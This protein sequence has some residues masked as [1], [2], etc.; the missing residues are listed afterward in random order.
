MREVSGDA[1]TTTATSRRQTAVRTRAAARC[2]SQAGSCGRAPWPN[3][4]P[5]S[6][7]VTSHP[8]TPTTKSCTRRG[9]HPS[10]SLKAIELAVCAFLALRTDNR[11]DPSREESFA[12]P[13]RVPEF[14]LGPCRWTVRGCFRPLPRPPARRRRYDDDKQRTGSDARFKSSS[15]TESDS[16]PFANEYAGIIKQ[17]RG[18]I[19]E[20]PHP[21]DYGR[22]GIG[23]ARLPP[24]GND[25]KPATPHGTRRA[26]KPRTCSMTSTTCLP[27]SRTNSMPCFS[28][29][30]R[31]APMT[32][33]FLK[34]TEN[35]EYIFV[36][37]IHLKLV[38]NSK[39]LGT[40]MGPI[41][42]FV[43]L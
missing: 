6:P 28:S 33:R 37:G 11:L 18:Q 25:I 8:T 30:R 26:Q 3:S 36:L 20:L 32:H 12:V 39:V 13:P 10:R 42:C 29:S 17:N 24:R 38:K 19:G 14:G 7:T 4:P 43:S 16:F 23:L 31:K 27:I 9:C 34:P 2:C 40:L 35:Q 1:C 21:V 5:R 41:N 22:P 15:S